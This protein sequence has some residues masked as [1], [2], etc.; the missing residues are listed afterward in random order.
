[1]NAPCDPALLQPAPRGAATE[2]T[3]VWRVRPESIRLSSRALGWGPVNIERREIEPASDF[4]PGG[5]TEHLI[6][7]NLADHHMVCESDG[8]IIEGKYAAGHVGVHPSHTPVRWE[9]N[10]RLNFLLMTLD[11]AFLNRVAQETFGHDS[12]TVELTF[13]DG[14][15]D[16][17]IS[18]IASALLREAVSGDVGNRMLAESLANVLAV[19]LIR[20]YSGRPAQASA[21][22]S[23][24]P[25]RAVSQA[26]R[27][28]HDNYARELSLADIGAAAR[29][30][31]FHLT[32]VFKKAMG[33]SP[34]Q[35]LVQV[36]VNSA[37]A[38]LTSG[39]GRQSLAEVA[40]AVGFSDQSHL[41]RQFKRVL[42][43]TPKQ[44]RL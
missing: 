13:S 4:L 21:E 33:M 10:T 18:N 6:F 24:M 7:V 31:S 14:K 25:T 29:L 9:W 32:R 22:V 35:Y 42:G 36:R 28:I 44:V 38:L 34:H 1:M 41:T 39:G 3:E 43:L 12:G 40:A 8:E 17:A 11:P 2:A 5:T 20:H 15:H 30:S 16:P 26:V 37:R 23:A 27:F 19:H